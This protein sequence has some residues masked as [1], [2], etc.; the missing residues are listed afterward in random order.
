MSNLQSA[1]Y[2]ILNE[3]KLRG[4][5]IPSIR[6]IRAR[7]Q[8]GSLT[9]I[10]QIVREWKEMNVPA[11]PQPA[12]GFDAE[13]AAD[14]LSGVWSVVGP[15]I[16]DRNKK[17]SESFRAKIALL[18][19]E[20]EDL[21]QQL[22]EARIEKQDL[23]EKLAEALSTATQ[24]HA[25]RIRYSQEATALREKLEQLDSIKAENTALKAQIELFQRQQEVLEAA[26]QE[27]RELRNAEKTK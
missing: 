17:F 22:D 20:K 26:L 7:T 2:A 3:S 6:A 15:I 13:Q 23:E 16:E 12:F 21:E 8:T 10:S 25:E 19:E 5:P 11:E 14:L 18:S 9:T 4:E 24:Y 1:I 27:L